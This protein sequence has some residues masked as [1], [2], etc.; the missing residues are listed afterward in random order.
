MYEVCLSLQGYTKMLTETVK[1]FN[2]QKG[3]GFVYEDRT[4][5]KFL[6]TIISLT[7][8]RGASVASQFSYNLSCI[9]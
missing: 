6:L 3:Y 1:W 7:G 8:T 5:K 2:N 4:K 9:R